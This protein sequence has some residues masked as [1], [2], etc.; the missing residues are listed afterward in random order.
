MKTTVD[1]YDFQRAFEQCR[2][3]SFSRQGLCVLFEYLEQYEEDCGEEIELDVIAICCDFSEDSWENIA[4]NY[5]IDLE[6]CEDEDEKAEVVRQYLEDEG[7]LVGDVS[8]G[9]VYRDF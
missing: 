4:D 6:D 1:F 8:G 3:D 5:R 7:T 2:P 9:F